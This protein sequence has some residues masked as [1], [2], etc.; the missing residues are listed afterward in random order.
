MRARVAILRAGVTVEL[1][2][3]KL[4]EKP[5]AFL[6]ASASATVP[7]LDTG[8]FVLDESI[9]IMEWALHQNDPD[10]LLDMTQADWDLIER[11]D[12]PFKA[13]LDHTKYAVRYP[14][15]DPQQERAKA[16]AVILDL[17]VR[18]EAARYL[19]G[20]R[21]TLADLAIFPF[22]RQFANIDRPW[23]D[24]QPWPNVITWLNGFLDSQEFQTAMEKFPLWGEAVHPVQFGESQRLVP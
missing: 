19:T 21:P 9:E 13:A 15:L 23:F 22:I 17:E 6:D 20:Q 8:A 3:I 24:A 10:G 7:A 2:E 11:N 16:S 12:G 4:K 1:R 5:P 18:L 14:D